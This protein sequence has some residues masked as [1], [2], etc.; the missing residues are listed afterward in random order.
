[1]ND[2]S[3]FNYRLRAAAEPKN[4]LCGSGQA[5]TSSRGDICARK[6]YCVTVR[7]GQIYSKILR[8]GCESRRAILGLQRLHISCHFERNGVLTGGTLHVNPELDFVRIQATKGNEAIV[9]CLCDL[10][11]SD[12]KNLGLLNLALDANTMAAF[13]NIDISPIDHATQNSLI[14]TI[15]HLKQVIFV[16]LGSAGRMY[17]G[18]LNGIMAIKGYELHG[19]RTI[20]TF[21]RIFN[22]FDGIQS[23]YTRT[24]GEYLW[25]HHAHEECYFGG[26]NMFKD[27]GH[28]MATTLTTNSWYVSVLKILGIYAVSLIVIAHPDGSEKRTIIGTKGKGG[29]LNRSFERA[30]QYL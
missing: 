23:P 10:R 22:A 13:D 15:R 17:L 5:G 1:M 18:P 25:E 28:G 9:P 26:R 6:Q 8:V 21:F 27:G 16:G 7:G 30:I 4:I 29:W 11:I 20:M 24:F 19:S 3:K 14:K 12:P 2:S